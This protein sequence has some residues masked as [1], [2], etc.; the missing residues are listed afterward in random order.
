MSATVTYVAGDQFAKNGSS[1]AQSLPQ[2][3][4]LTR[5][6][7]KTQNAVQGT[8]VDVKNPYVNAS[9]PAPSAQVI[10]ANSEFSSFLQKA[11]EYV[12][13]IQTEKTLVQ[14]IGKFDEAIKNID[15]IVAERD[16]L[17]KQNEQAIL[18][19]RQERQALLERD[20]NLQSRATDLQGKIAAIDT[21]LAEARK[22]KMEL[23]A[24]REAIRR[25]KEAG[26]A[27]IASGEAKIAAAQA[28][29]ARGLEMRKQALKDIALTVTI[30][31][32]G[33]IFG[34]KGSLLSDPEKEAIYT[35]YLTEGGGFYITSDK[36]NPQ[37]SIDSMKTVVEFS[38]AN[39]YA[40]CNMNKILNVKDFGTL[41]SY[42]AE[43]TCPI[44]LAGFGAKLS[45]ID[46]DALAQAVIARRQAPQKLTVKLVDAETNT[47]YEAALKAKSA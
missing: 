44:K 3:Q 2:D 36:A 26:Q 34:F 30:P 20:E 6:V 9:R 13:V 19:N 42:L 5:V 31:T 40:Q 24:R 14:E 16:V 11:T 12:K 17:F 47:K 38:R 15:Q 29:R 1:H 46:I 18:Q 21:V 41:A 37:I 22:E 32:L 25:K 43:S 39:K 27:K 35:K 23:Q 10:Q 33:N 45:D 4:R 28:E 7:A 8:D